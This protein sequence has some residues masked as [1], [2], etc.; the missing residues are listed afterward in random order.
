MRRAGV[1]RGAVRAAW[2]VGA[3]CLAIVGGE[4]LAAGPR[5]SVVAAGDAA[6]LERL[7]AREAADLLRRLF[8]ADATVDEAPAADASGY[9]LIG[10]PRS[11]R[12]VQAAAGSGWPELSEQGHVVRSCELSGRPAV[13]VGGGSPVATLW[14]AYELGAQFGVRYL[15]DRDVPP[16]Q[17]PAFRLTGFNLRLEPTLQVRCWRTVDD[18]PIGPESWGSEDQ[19]RLVRQLAKLKFNRLSIATHAWQPFVHFEHG[20]T[21][22]RTGVLFR[23]DK[24]PV[25]GDTA[26][27]AA[28][29]GAAW[30]ENPDFAG[31]TEYAQR[32]EAGVKLVNGLVD[33]AHDVGLSV[34]LRVSPLEFPLEFAAELPGAKPVAGRERSAVGPGVGQT[35]GDPAF[36]ALAV[37]QLAAY[38]QAYPRIDG[39]ELTL[40]E[41]AEGDESY[42]AAWKRLGERT[43]V[44]KSVDLQRLTQAVRAARAGAAE[45]SGERNVRALYGAL[46]ALDAIHELATDS[47]L[48]ARP[49]GRPLELTVAGIDPILA[50]VVDRVL[51]PGATASYSL[52]PSVRLAPEAADLPGGDPQSA[53]RRRLTLV[54]SDDGSGLLPQ[55][56]TT[57]LH[58]S[59]DRLRKSGWQ[60]YSTRHRVAGDL[61]PAVHYLSRAAF[62]AQATPESADADLIDAVSGEGVAQS[63]TK[64]FRLI[65]QATDRI[66]REDP[67]FAF[68]APDVVMK[69][70]AAAAPAPAWWADVRTAYARAMDEMYRGNTR[71]REGARP[72]TLYYAKRL[73]FAVHYM[74]SLEALRAAGA[75]K[76]KGDQD[77]QLAQLEKAV[78]SMYNALNAYGE[79]ARDPSDRGVIAVLNE[80]GYRKLVAELDAAGS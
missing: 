34:A 10:S 63:V 39:M 44:D 59:T 30:F 13:A 12:F 49:A 52:D 48:W 43:G 74:T 54:L 17:K 79:V 20:R 36:K 38:L 45:E 56:P 66:D 50:P 6:P 3:A 11:N 21:A 35:P 69:H 60:G 55:L 24:F 8:D 1:M 58:A 73:E 18:S 29:K 37:A 19:R 40:P 62:D 32:V 67:Q 25:D 77:E 57:R 41:R 31:K 68:P 15:L 2:V 70:Y 51:P 7:A 16:A 14:A 27:R 75:A 80:F 4:A 71:A 65:E 5:V 72:F 53:A 23:G 42:A 28:F 47:K 33:A 64:G 76:A 9:V 46:V 26:G 61:Y 78:E 22:K